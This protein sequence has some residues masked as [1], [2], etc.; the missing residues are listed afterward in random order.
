[1]S[2]FIADLFI[3]TEWL[4]RQR[5][6]TFENILPMFAEHKIGW[7]QC[8]L[9]ASRTQTYIPWGFKQVDPV[10]EIWQHDTFRADGTPYD[11][12]EMKQ[13]RKFEFRK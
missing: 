12:N 3:C 5:G 6:N 8:G 7:Y 11:L 4:H 13:V 9:V 1:M 2:D 10:P